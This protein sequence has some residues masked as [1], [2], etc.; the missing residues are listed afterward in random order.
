MAVLCERCALQAA[1]E[2]LPMIDRV[3][4]EWVWV[5]GVSQAQASRRLGVS[6]Q[7]VAK[8]LRCIRARLQQSLG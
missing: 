2:G 1:L 5:A 6:Q 7:A 4:V 8:R 3:L